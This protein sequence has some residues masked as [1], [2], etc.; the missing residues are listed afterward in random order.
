MSTGSEQ[1]QP[2]LLSQPNTVTAVLSRCLSLLPC[3]PTWLESIPFYSKG[4]W[5]QSDLRDH[6]PGKA[7][8]EFCV[9]VSW[10]PCPQNK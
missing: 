9:T 3:D 7:L 4:G 8:L 2:L 1:S 10:A 5:E 6:K